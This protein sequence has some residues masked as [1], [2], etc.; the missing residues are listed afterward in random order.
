LV[1]VAA[2]AAPPPP[3]LAEQEATRAENIAASK[4]TLDGVTCADVKKAAYNVL[5]LID[6][7]DM[8]IEAQEDRLL[9]G[10]KF[11]FIAIS[12]NS[13]GQDW[14]EI[15]WKDVNGACDVSFS[16]GQDANSTPIIPVAT[17]QRV[18]ADLP[19]SS[20]PNFR[21]YAKLFYERLDY[22]LGRRSDWPEC[23]VFRELNG[24]TPIPLC[25]GLSGGIGVADQP[26]SFLKATTPSNTK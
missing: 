10:R 11:V 6:P 17:T 21:F 19:I 16:I 20:L 12:M 23:K 5:Y 1:L 14:Y 26:P 2:C 15:K 13:T 8:M 9:G 25:G 7:S 4:R 24:I 18:M 3:N 22:F